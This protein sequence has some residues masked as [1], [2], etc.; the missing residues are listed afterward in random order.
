ME[1]HHTNH[2]Q[3]YYVNGLIA[4]EDAYFKALSTH[5]QIVSTFGNTCVTIS[6]LILLV[7]EVLFQAF[8]L[9]VCCSVSLT[10]LCSCTSI[11]TSRPM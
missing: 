9:Q 7:V 2:H 6:P 3:A 1:L 11:K 5:D 10:D 8:Y 4:P